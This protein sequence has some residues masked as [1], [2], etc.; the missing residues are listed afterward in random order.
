[1]TILSYKHGHWVSETNKQTNR[2]TKNAREGCSIVQGSRTHD[3][4]QEIP[5]SFSA[6]MSKKMVQVQVYLILSKNVHMKPHTI[7]NNFTFIN[8]LLGFFFLEN[9]IHVYNVLGLHSLPLLSLS[10]SAATPS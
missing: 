8:T 1:M 10:Q 9:F 5:G 4:H 3:D 6:P 7:Y 2:Q